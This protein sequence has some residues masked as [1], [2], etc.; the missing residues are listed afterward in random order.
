MPAEGVPQLPDTP[1]RTPAE[2]LKWVHM[3]MR[4]GGARVLDS[5][6]DEAVNRD[7]RL[8]SEALAIA[9]DY[10][11]DD[12]TRKSAFLAGF[13][14]R[15]AVDMHVNKDMFPNT[16]AGLAEQEAEGI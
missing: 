10:S 8:M 11:P 9:H 5:L 12:M 13:V 7:Q 4:G 3:K 1:Q 16:P 6:M 15:D 14:A 2:A